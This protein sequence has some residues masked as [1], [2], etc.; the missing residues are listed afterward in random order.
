M[1]KKLLTIADEIRW[2]MR[3]FGGVR[4]TRA[5]H[6][7]TGAVA[8]LCSLAG[9]TNDH[10]QPIIGNGQS[11]DTALK[12][13][14]NQLTQRSGSSILIQGRTYRWASGLWQEFL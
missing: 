13:F 12:D 7:E 11:E 1:N 10:G 3:P 9:A 8:F 6:T 14:W 2:A 5:T 4:I